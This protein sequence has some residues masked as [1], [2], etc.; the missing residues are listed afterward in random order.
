MFKQ[1]NKTI[2]INIGKPILHS[3]LDKT[4]TNTEWAQKI[5]NQVY[6]LGKNK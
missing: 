5:R 3:S 2:N 1:R 6:Q 4:A